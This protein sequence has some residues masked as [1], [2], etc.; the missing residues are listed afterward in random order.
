MVVTI[1]AIRVVIARAAAMSVAIPWMMKE[2]KEVKEH[3]IVEM[4]LL[5]LKRCCY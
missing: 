5:N 3:F 1:I 2:V 4:E